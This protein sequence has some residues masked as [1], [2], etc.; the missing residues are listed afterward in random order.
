MSLGLSSTSDVISF[1]QNW[2]HLYSTALRG[3]DLSNDAQFRVIGRMELAICRKM[4]KKL[5]EKIRAKF[6]ATT[7]G[8][9]MVKIARLD[10]AFLEDF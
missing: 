5:I 7:R 10:D 1:H 2:Y 3:K 9:A 4:L 6:P 8:Y